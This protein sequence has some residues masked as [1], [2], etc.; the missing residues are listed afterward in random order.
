MA[1]KTLFVGVFVR[2]FPEI[3]IWIYILNKDL[4]LQC[5]CVQFNQLRA[6]IEQK[7]RRRNSASLLEPRTTLI[8]FPS[9]AR[10]PALRTQDSAAIQKVLG[11]VPLRA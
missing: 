3:S 2:M 5:G 1:D 8:L 9:D 6:R 10:A 4:F 7:S 11:F